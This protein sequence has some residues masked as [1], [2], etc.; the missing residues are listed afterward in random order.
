MLLNAIGKCTCKRADPQIQQIHRSSRSAD[1]ADPADTEKSYF[2]RPPYTALQKIN[3]LI[4]H[5]NIYLV[6][7]P[8]LPQLQSLFWHL[9]P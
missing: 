8:Q 9:F 3:P 7:L 2:P 1:S 6:Q 4:L 5:E